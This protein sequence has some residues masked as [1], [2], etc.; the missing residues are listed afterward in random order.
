MKRLLLFVL[1]TAMVLA[2]CGEHAGDSPTAPAPSKTVTTVPEQQANVTVKFSD[3]ANVTALPVVVVDGRSLLLDK[4][5]PVSPENS[6]RP[7]SSYNLRLEPGSHEIR[8]TLDGNPP[9]VLAFEV[10]EAHL[11]IGVTFWGKRDHSHMSVPVTGLF[12]SD[13]KFA[14]Q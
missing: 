5:R 1:V 7:G 3:E 12:T 11:W 9:D 2:G 10:G 6:S 13:E 14:Y 4:M 8:S